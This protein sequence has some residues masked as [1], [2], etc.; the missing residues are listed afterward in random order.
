MDTDCINQSGDSL[1]HCAVKD[2]NLEIVQ[3]LLGRPDIDQN[4]ANKDGDT[5]LHSAVCGEQLDIVQLLL[6][7]ADI[8][9]NRENKVRMS[10]FA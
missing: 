8:D 2:G 9:P 5:P 10:L 6:D 3:L 4:K 1:L 7:R